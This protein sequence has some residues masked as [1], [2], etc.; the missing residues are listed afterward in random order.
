MESS[1]VVIIII[2]CINKQQM[3]KWV[4]IKKGGRVFKPNILIQVMWLLVT[5]KVGHS[6]LELIGALSQS[7][8]CSSLSSCAEASVKALA[9]EM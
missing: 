2:C 8:C 5:S 1:V 3:A 7:C 4:N 9:A 6:F